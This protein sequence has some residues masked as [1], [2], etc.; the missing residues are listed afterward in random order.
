MAK[1]SASITP[2]ES[3]V[4]E[5]LRQ[6]FDDEP[7]ASVWRHAEPSEASFAVGIGGRADRQPGTRFR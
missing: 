1:E 7:G 2:V 4:E 3:V 6:H 5:W